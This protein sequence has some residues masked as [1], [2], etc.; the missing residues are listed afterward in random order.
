MTSATNTS[1]LAANARKDFLHAWRKSSQER[2]LH[3]MVCG[4]SGVGMSALINRLLQ[5]EG[6][7]RAKEGIMGRATTTAVFKYETIP[8][9]VE[10]KCMCLFDSPGFGGT[11][12][13]D[14]VI[15]DMMEKNWTWFSIASA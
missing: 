5:L 8:P 13:S 4:L 12:I 6:E 10:S 7:E 11:E 15:I 9:R 2:P 14:E 3:V 1:E